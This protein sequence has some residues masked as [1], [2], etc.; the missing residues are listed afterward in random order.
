MVHPALARLADRRLAEPAGVALVGALAL[1]GSIAEAYPAHHYAGLH[2]EGHP[3]PWAFALVVVPALALW[4]RRTHPLTVFAIA[5]AAVAGWA[6]T[7]QVYGA[8]LVVVLVALYALAVS[9]V[10][11][12][13]LAALA[14]GGTLLIWL[15]GG[16]FGPWGWLG[17]P[18]LDMW[19]EMLAAGAFGAAVAARRQW[20]QSEQRN[21]LQAARAHE[22]ETRRQVDSERLRIAREL[23][24]VVAHSMAVINV[25]ASA[26]A[27]LVDDDPARARD[28]IQ[29]IR[30]ASKDGLR[31]LRS[32]LEVLRQVDGDEPAVPLP[33]ADAV[34]ALVEA[35]CAAGSPARLSLTADLAELSPAAALAAYRIVQESLT[36][37]VR[38][39]P[40]SAT[41][42]SLERRGDTL[43]VVVRDDGTGGVGGGFAD[44]AGSGLT[45]MR[46]RASALGGS[47]SAARR[48]GGGFEVRAE[49]PVTGGAA[50]GASPDAAARTG[51][52]AGASR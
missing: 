9:D 43:L 40:G 4:W 47:L 51:S 16:V 1:A 50:R 12:I 39:S 45:G 27:V 3:A 2:L 37:V 31:E 42:V 34:R 52:A 17:G 36:N 13:R 22:E 24:D 8:A 14:V 32:I 48:D 44:G 41:Q 11:R 26:A 19:A 25:Q 15:V 5:V 10:A 21:R 46:E 18:Q 33:G 49:L 28:A 23:H 7:G 38:H 29:A 6:G 30:R 35:T 20:R